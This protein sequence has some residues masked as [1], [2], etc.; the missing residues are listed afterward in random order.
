MSGEVFKIETG[1]EKVTKTLDGYGR[2]SQQSLA[3]IAKNNAYDCVRII[4]SPGYCPVRTGMLRN[5]HYVARSG[6]IQYDIKCSVRYWIHVVYGKKEG[7]KLVKLGKLQKESHMGHKKV[8]GVGKTNKLHKA[9]PIPNNYP[10]RAVVEMH[11]GG[12]MDRNVAK[13]LKRK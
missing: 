11:R 3:N 12:H 2:D 9:K 4:K 8:K 5:G 10:R 7:H 1:L 13:E 6:Q